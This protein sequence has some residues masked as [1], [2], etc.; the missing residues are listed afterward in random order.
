M[1]DT[2]RIRTRIKEIRRRLL[3]LNKFKDIR[4]E[5]FL[6]DEHLNA[7]TERH[8]QVAIQCCLDIANHIVASMGLDRPTKDQSEVFQSLAKEKIIPRKTVVIL[9]KITSYRNILVHEYIA[10]D[11]RVTYAN[12]RKHLK[13]LSQFVKHIERFLQ[14]FQRKV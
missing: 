13:D 4:Q 7:E 9:R 2:H 10:V 12:I 3:L 8:L 14:K 11:R 6:S 1:L 5:D